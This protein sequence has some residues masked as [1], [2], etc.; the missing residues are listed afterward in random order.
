[1]QKGDTEKKM[2]THQNTLPSDTAA[3]KGT[4][5]PRTT[6]INDAKTKGKQRMATSGEATDRHNGDASPPR[7][8]KDRITTS[9][10]V[11]LNDAATPF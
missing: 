3:P 11:S 7:D 5:R 1:M 6:E 10:S 9:V 4:Q 2:G 8:P